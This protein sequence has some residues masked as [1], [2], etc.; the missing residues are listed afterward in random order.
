MSERR[1]EQPVIRKHEPSLPEQFVR[2]L[3]GEEKQPIAA[4]NT[5]G[6]DC[7]PATSCP[8]QPSRTHTRYRR[9]RCRPSHNVG[10]HRPAGPGFAVAL[11][12]RHLSS[13]EVVALDA[14]RSSNSRYGV[15]L[16]CA[17]RAPRRHDVERHRFRFVDVCPA[18]ITSRVL[19]E[20][21]PH[22]TLGQCSDTSTSRFDATPDC[23]RPA[24]IERVPKAVS[25]EC[26]LD[27]KRSNPIG[28]DPIR[29]DLPNPES[30]RIP[31]YNRM[32]NSISFEDGHVRRIPLL[33]PRQPQTSHEACILYGPRDTAL[34]SVVTA[35]CTVSQCRCNTHRRIVSLLDGL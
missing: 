4:S 16:L 30:A 29:R 2:I 3:V 11:E 26:V 13:G 5:S 18:R 9:V 20:F 19:K 34:G 22:V 25:F 27:L 14:S 12:A 21:R 33:Q 17:R 31:R 32:P 35:R 10:R 23:C 6:F 24:A 28:I 15:V 8:V 1:S 7:S